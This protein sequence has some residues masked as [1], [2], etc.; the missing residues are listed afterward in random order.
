M[1]TISSIAVF[2]IVIIAECLH[3]KRIKKVASLAFGPDKKAKSWTYTIPI[4]RALAATWLCWSLLI[5]MN[6][7]SNSYIGNS[8]DEVKEE[9]SSD[10]LMIILDVS[11]SMYLQDSGAFG[12]LRRKQRARQVLESLMDRITNPHIKYSIV[13]C[14]TDALPVV[15]DTVDR[16]LIANILDLPMDQAFTPGK[17][18]LLKG[19]EKAFELSKKWPPGSTSFVLLSD[20][21]FVEEEGMP[22]PPDCMKEFIAAGVGSADGLFID[23]HQSRQ[24]ALTLKRLARRLQGVYQDVNERHLSTQILGSLT[25]QKDESSNAFTIRE[26]ALFACALSSF[27]LATLPVLLN[28]FAYDHKQERHKIRKLTNFAEVAK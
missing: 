28:Y 5:L 14:F 18:K 13:A 26:W 12:E 2:I 1:V 15:I 8:I 27:L 25:T 24:D 17:T 21:D 4:L 10:R 20:G 22:N 19:I 11:P 9:E 7:N 3:L 23:G 16:N 6:L